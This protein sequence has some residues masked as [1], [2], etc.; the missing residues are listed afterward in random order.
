MES[1]FTGIRMG[2]SIFIVRTYL[3]SVAPKI[4][5]GKG[6]GGGHDTYFGAWRG[7]LLCF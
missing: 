7:K 4:W 6:I 1:G 3:S 2:I 5:E